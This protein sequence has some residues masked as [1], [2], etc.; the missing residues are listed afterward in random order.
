M[1]IKPVRTIYPILIAAVLV[2]LTGCGESGSVTETHI[3]PVSVSEA[4]VAINPVMTAESDSVDSEA[5]PAPVTNLASALSVPTQITR[6]GDFF[7][8]VD[9]YN[10][11]VIYSDSLDKPLNEWYVMTRDIDKGH[12]VASD[13]TV[14]LVDDT[15]RNRV[16]SFEYDGNVFNCTGVFE[17]IGNRP[18]YIVY[19]EADRSFYV[20]SS[21]TGE[22]YVFERSEGSTQVYISRIM[23]LDELDGI[24]VR[25]FTIVD[26]SVYLVSGNSQIIEARLS[27]FKIKKRYP[28]PD[29]L[30]GMIQIMPVPGGYYITISTDV[31]GNQDFATIIFAEELSDLESGAYTDIYSFF[32]GGGTPYYMGVIDGR[33]YL[34]EH[35][36]PGHSIWSFDIGE[37]HMPADVTAV[38]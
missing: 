30:A 21:M 17:G 12:T 8:I 9:C 4:S 5:G 34:T 22:M 31:H 25:S 15:E 6:I 10:D 26:D 2:L 1:T 33:Y 20:W 7:F 24:Y 38:Y 28:V 14:Y 35:R 19:N 18:H 32:V 36:L 23:K 11:Q 13:G 29:E 37:D 16:L 27:D 3:D